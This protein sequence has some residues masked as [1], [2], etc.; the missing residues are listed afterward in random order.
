[1]EV[2]EKET[3]RTSTVGGRTYYFCSDACKTRFDQEPER[4]ATK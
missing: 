2:D 1:M 3:S 4:F